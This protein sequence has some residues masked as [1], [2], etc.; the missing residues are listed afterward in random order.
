M[1]LFAAPH[2]GCLAARPAQ[3]MIAT[4][5]ASDPRE[6]A[7]A[8]LWVGIP[9]FGSISGGS[10][11]GSQGTA[12]DA[13]TSAHLADLR[14]SG[15][16]LFRRNISSIE[17]VRNLCAALRALLGD[18]LFVAVDQE[19][20][21]VERFAGLLPSW[22][23][24]MALGAIAMREPTLGE[25]LAREQGRLCGM[26]LRDAGVDVV[27]AP[28]LDLATTGANPSTGIRS[29]GATPELAARLGVAMIS[30]FSDAGVL[31]CAKHFPGLGAARVDSH[32][33]LPV[34]E[35]RDHSVHL[36]P[37]RDAVQVGVPLVMTSHVVYT[38]LD[39]NRPA[40]F[41]RAICTE[42]LRNQLGFAGLVLT[43]DM[44]MGAIV[45]RFGFA[46]AVRDAFAAGHDVLTVCSSA[47]LQ[48]EAR[49]TL[50]QEIARDESAAA[51]ARRSIER[52]V[53][54]RSAW[55]AASAPPAQP[56]N[57]APRAI[58]AHIAAQDADAVR[59][60]SITAAT[61]LSAAIAGRAITVVQ[62]VQGLVPLRSTGSALLLLPVLAAGTPVEDP[63]RGES[64]GSALATALAARCEVLRLP[65]RPNAQECADALA[66]AARY[67]IVLLA[68]TAAST[69]P[70][71]ATLAQSL[72]AA[73]ERVVL[74]ALRSP[75]DLAVVAAVSDAACVAAARNQCAKAT[76]VASYGFREMQLS[77][78]AKVLLGQ[79]QPFGWAPIDL[80][81]DY[82]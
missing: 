80:E 47:A 75:F 59:S 37:F 6:L 17:Q 40:T 21:L 78:L 8:L 32:L 82:A 7:G 24:N 12:L 42:L 23:G 60:R 11:S 19:G 22:P 18:E 56:V 73:H 61:A 71:Q 38:A 13:A 46:A 10:P 54:L 3:R 55:A 74:L 57:A 63:M 31:S 44:E 79:T 77:A 67:D 51:A 45:K 58:L 49:D 36:R 2:V 29:F 70:A 65:A 39:S 43:D 5:M 62:D 20:G 34:V 68:L 28:A 52:A 33:D 50:V 66:A 35:L 30:G 41:S 4:L 64:D 9:A 72:C 16:I 15:V 69:I 48:R 76:L 27:L 1:T 53:N 81:G 25:H 26:L 14:P